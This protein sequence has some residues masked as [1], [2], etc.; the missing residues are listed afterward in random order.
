M[1][2]SKQLTAEFFDAIYSIVDVM[3]DGNRIHF[4]LAV[5]SLDVWWSDF[6]KLVHELRCL[7]ESKINTRAAR[8][9]NMQ[10]KGILLVSDSAA[11][12]HM[13]RCSH[14]QHKTNI[15]I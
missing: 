4:D 3:G 2:E 13:Q 12:C 11:I 8:D 15:F 6:F 5:G 1:A 10:P 14:S 7:S 9:L